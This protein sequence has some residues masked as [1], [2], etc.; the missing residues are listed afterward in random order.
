MKRKEIKLFKYFKNVRKDLKQILFLAF[1]LY[2]SIEFIFNNYAEIFTNADKVGQLI[3][4]LS[5]SYIS[6]FIFYFVVVH[7]KSENDKENINEYLGYKVYS[8]ITSAHLII[9][10]MLQK[11][12]NKA[13]FEY[14]DNEKLS[15]LLTSINRADK[16]APLRFKD[17][18][19]NANW[20]EWLAYLKESTEKSLSEIYVRYTHMDSKLIKILTR[21]ENSL[22]IS[23]FDLLLNF[24]YDKT[25]TLYDLQIR[26]YLKHIKDLEDYADK[27][28]KKFKYRNGEFVGTK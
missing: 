25:F 4:K 20:M 27:N 26:T 16:E 3:S 2:F 6:A 7:I 18:N 5:I 9:Q 11:F 19:E 23:Q 22:Y 28:F 1:S 15:N 10:P 14:L 12:D 21:I 8:I 24:E 13:R 17:E